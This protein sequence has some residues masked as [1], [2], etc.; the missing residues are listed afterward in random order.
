MLD[1]NNITWDKRTHVTRQ[2]KKSAFIRSNPHHEEVLRYILIHECLRLTTTV[3]HV[4]S[5]KATHLAQAEP[6]TRSME[7]FNISTHPFPNSF[8][9]GQAHTWAESIK[10]PQ[11]DP[12]KPKS[13]LRCPSI[14]GLGR[15][16]VKFVV[17]RMMMWTE[18]DEDM[19]GR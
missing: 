10:P 7:S 9:P 6:Q 3:K 19:W 4:S 1:H 17:L 18:L 11:P 8:L 13:K 5:D 14:R 15:D 12:T 16:S 2:I